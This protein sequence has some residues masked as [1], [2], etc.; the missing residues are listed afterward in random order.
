[1]TVQALESDANALGE[2]PPMPGLTLRVGITGHRPKPERLPP[3]SISFVT[4]RLKEVFDAVDR[5]LSDLIEKYQDYYEGVP[6]V[7]LVSGLA[8]GADQL[9]VAAMPAAWALDAILP[10]PRDHYVKDFETPLLGDGDSAVKTFTNLVDRA[11]TVLELPTESVGV[12]GGG[13]EA[14]EPLGLAREAAYVRLG[15]FLLRQ[16]DILVAVWDDKADEGRGGTGD[17]VRAA[18]AAGIP[19]VWINPLHGSPARIIEGFDERGKTIAPDA[20]C[21]KGSLSEAIDVLIGIAEAKSDSD[22]KLEAEP[23]AQRLK[24]Y[25]QETW[26]SPSRWIAYD[27]FRRVVEGKPIRSAIASDR[28]EHR[29]RWDPPPSQIPAVGPLRASLEEML[30][31]RFAW[32]EA[33]ASAYSHRYRSAYIVCY[34]L[35]SCAVAVALMGVFAHDWFRENHDQLLLA[36]AILVLI[37]LLLIGFVVWIVTQG[38]RERWKEKWMEY[39]C[40]AELLL[41]ARFL[42]FVGEHGRAHRFGAASTA[43]GWVLWYLRATIREIGLP[44]ASLD[45]TYQRSLLG[46]LDRLVVTTQRNW[47][48]GN[49]AALR[50]MDQWLH[51]FADGCFL[52]TAVVLGAFLLGCACQEALQLWGDHAAAEWL[53]GHLVASTN[54]LTFFAALLPAFGAAAAGVRE[55]GDFGKVAERSTKTVE[56]LNEISGDIKKARSTL[57]LDETGDMLLTTAQI[58]TEDL[59]AWQSVYGHKRLELP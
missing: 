42:A 31:P 56:A 33:L 25:A 11:E 35:A 50:R 7:R 9:A 36:K 32:A 4:N 16:I 3:Q 39:R 1:M 27:A 12:R 49:A 15:G 13:D 51:R 47:H 55:T 40:L 19:T 54:L 17:V 8:E 22:E 28:A 46:A 45:G 14:A 20:D 18:V 23:V 21:T 41:N 43:N 57:R 59:A 53:S 52:L 30:L 44:S 34:T 10:L 26:P 48:Q 24:D 58:L 29:L 38:R 6:K 2:Y 5:A 37:E